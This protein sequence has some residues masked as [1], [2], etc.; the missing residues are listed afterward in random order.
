M[1]CLKFLIKTVIIIFA[2]IG[3]RSTGCWDW[4]VNTFHLNKKP[5]QES[6][7]E[8][9]RDVADFSDIP[10]EYEIAKSANILGYRAVIAE[11]CATGQKFAV[12]NENKGLKLTQKDFKDGSLKKKIDA[13]NQ[14]LEYQYIHVKN[15]T[16]LKQGKMKAMG[17]TVPYA[18]FEADVTNLPVKTLKGIISV[19]SD[20]DGKGKILVAANE[21]DKYSQIISEQFFKQVKLTETPE[22]AAD[23]DKNETNNDKNTENDTKKEKII[24]ETKEKI[25][26]TAQKTRDAVEKTLESKRNGK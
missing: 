9:S 25:I 13:V 18:L 3:F 5:S 26:D 16:I 6:M 17:Q 4:C 1:G 14:K 21:R 19:A 20:K 7:I 12:V 2:I 24:T 23:K 11:H 10:E 15:F 8:K 22:K